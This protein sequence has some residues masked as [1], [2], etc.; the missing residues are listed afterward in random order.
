MANTN[1]PQFIRRDK[2]TVPRFLVRMMFALVLI[3]LGF[4][5]FATVTDRRGF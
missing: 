5:T 2:E 4:V 1:Q 3:V